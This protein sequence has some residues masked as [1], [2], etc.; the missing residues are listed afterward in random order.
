MQEQLIAFKDTTRRKVHEIRQE[1]DSLEA[2]IGILER[3]RSESWELVGHRLHSTL[4]RTAFSLSDRM[5]ELENM[6]QSQGTTPA[7]RSDQPQINPEEIAQLES[8]IEARYQ[9]FAEEVDQMR[10][11]WDRATQG[12]CDLVKTW[13]RERLEHVD[14]QM[15][16]LKSFALHVEKYIAGQHS[17]GDGATALG[18]GSG[19]DRG[20][21]ARGCQTTPTEQVSGASSSTR[22][23]N[24]VQIPEPPGMP[25]PPPQSDSA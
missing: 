9:A 4:D 13:R 19:Q 3:A 11:D 5:T 10:E 12:H 20:R 15:K 7:T 16:G 1:T 8:H 18:T 2:K 23:L 17:S 14:H 22:P 24:Y 25:A 6:I 21:S